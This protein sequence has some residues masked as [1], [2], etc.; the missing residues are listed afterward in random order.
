MTLCRRLVLCLCLAGRATS[1]HGR[2]GGRS[3]TRARRTAARAAPRALLPELVR[4]GAT[5]LEPVVPVRKA[6]I[7]TAAAVS[8]AVALKTVLDRP[9][10]RYAADGESNSVADEYD[11]WTEDGIL[12]YYWGEHIHLGYYTD[13]EMAAG[14]KKKDFIAAKYDFI[15]EMMKW[16]GVGL[17]VKEATD[18]AAG[19]AP[20]PATPAA[21]LRVLD[22]G[23]GIG[24]TSRY[25][26]SKLGAAANVT[27]ITLSPKQVARG[28]SLVRERGL[29]SHCQLRVCDAL[30]MDFAD[31]SFDVVWACESGEHMPDKRKYV[32]EMARVLRPGGRIAIATWCQRDNRTA[33]FTPKEE[34]D[35]DYLYAEWTHPYFISI[36][37]YAELMGATALD[38]VETADWNKETIASWRHSIWVGVWDP[39]PVVRRP[40]AWWKTVRD[41]VCLERMHRAFD[42]GLMQYGM[43]TA[44]KAAPKAE[45][46]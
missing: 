8:G 7:A 29:E 23:C 38:K 26:A 46:A 45:A 18:K 6:A 5:V 37:E 36:E 40:R 39:W 42:R 30:A 44:T 15:D 9:S 31:D 33:P 2:A 34:S 13:A 3:W 20:A 21:P 24:G 22:V 11:A 10:R 41:G 4:G 14:Y 28:M 12:E 43:M 1:F 32:E 16:G 35:L 27:G 19:R 25:I 17:E